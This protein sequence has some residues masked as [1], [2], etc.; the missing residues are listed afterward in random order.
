MLQLR[1]H[2][3]PDP[4]TTTAT[5]NASHDELQ[6]DGEETRAEESAETRL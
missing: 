1:E 2:L 6:R 3:M 4:T 5:S